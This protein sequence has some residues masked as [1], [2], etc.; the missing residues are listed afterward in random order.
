MTSVCETYQCA[1]ARSLHLFHSSDNPVDFIDALFIESKHN[2]RAI[3]LVPELLSE[4]I[5]LREAMS[6]LLYSAESLLD[7]CKSHDGIN[8]EPES[9]ESARALLADAK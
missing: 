7:D 3:A 2:A 5:R 4:V 8:G 9:F 1:W 6:A